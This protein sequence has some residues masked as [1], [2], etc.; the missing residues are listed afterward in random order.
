MP[1]I[2]GFG[3]CIVLCKKCSWSDSEKDEWIVDMVVKEVDELGVSLRYLCLAVTLLWKCF[4]TSMHCSGLVGDRGY[5]N[6][7]CEAALTAHVR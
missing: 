3:D 5:H 1:K 2:V 4:L 6:I 7:C